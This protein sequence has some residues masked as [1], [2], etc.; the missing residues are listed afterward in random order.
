[1]DYECHVTVKCPSLQ[2]DHLQNSIESVNWSFSQITN[3]PLLGKD[4]FCYAT[5]HYETLAH[6][7][8]YTIA[9]SEAL[10]LAGFTVLRR[11]VEQIMMDERYQQDE[12]RV[13]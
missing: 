12:W 10:Q 8:Q 5:N 7:I 11:K 4:T 9:L 3:D 13:V 1:M 6:A 2:L